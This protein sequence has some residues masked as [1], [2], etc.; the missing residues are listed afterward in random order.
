MG[1]SVLGG[2]T[3]SLKME[4]AAKEFLGDVLR[5]HIAI[6]EDAHTILAEHIV[7]H[8]LTAFSI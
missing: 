5:A 1:I 4:Y 3:L 2:I 8:S 7:Q 6:A